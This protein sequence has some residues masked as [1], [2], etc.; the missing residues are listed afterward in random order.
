MIYSFKI[1]VYLN[2]RAKF[3]VK[4]KF[5]SMFKIKKNTRDN[6]FKE[7][8]HLISWFYLTFSYITE[9]VCSFY[10]FMVFSFANS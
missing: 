8:I 9:S 3:W 6:K 1:I 7:F 4:K 2:Y 10:K 5:V